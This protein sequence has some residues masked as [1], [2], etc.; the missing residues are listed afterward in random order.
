M[1]GYAGESLLNSSTARYTWNNNND[2]TTYRI[3]VRNCCGHQAAIG[4]S[5][6]QARRINYHERRSRELTAG[7][8]R[9]Q[10]TQERAL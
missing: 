7:A 6:V 9:P 2:T 1:S 4:R 5:A 10:A 8:T 3:G